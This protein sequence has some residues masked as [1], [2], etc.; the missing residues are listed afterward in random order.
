VSD[1]RDLEA[2]MARLEVSLSESEAEVALAREARRKSE[3]EA[4]RLLQELAGVRA[5]LAAVRSRLAERET[6]VRN[7]HASVVWKLLQA[8]RGLFHRRW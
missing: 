2:E 1:A 3:D 6:Y 5:D 7:L 4:G 8:V